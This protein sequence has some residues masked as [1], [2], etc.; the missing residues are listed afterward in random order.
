MWQSPVGL[1]LTDNAIPIAVSSARDHLLREPSPSTG[2]PLHPQ[3]PSLN[4]FLAR[5]ASFNTN[6]LFGRSGKPHT[7]VM[8]RKIGTA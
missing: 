2:A 6:I 5:L 4:R 8:E 1:A 3:F 7:A